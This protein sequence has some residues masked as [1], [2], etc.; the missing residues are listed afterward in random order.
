MCCTREP[1]VALSARTRLLSYKLKQ[2]ALAG[3]HRTTLVSVAVS[4]CDRDDPNLSAEIRS[5]AESDSIVDFA[6]YDGGLANDYLRERGSFLP[7]DERELVGAVLASPRALWEV[8][9]VERGRG[10]VLRNAATAETIDVVDRIASG[11]VE[12][13]GLMLSRVA[14]LTDQICLWGTPIRIPLPLRASVLELLDTKPD[15]D[16]LASWYADVVASFRD[17]HG[18]DE[19]PGE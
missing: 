16:Q 17:N 18:H 2:F 14:R 15:A 19:D 6:L 11:D 1:K 12:V 7:V 3:R 8:V 9:D 10:L 4:A 5:L 13:G